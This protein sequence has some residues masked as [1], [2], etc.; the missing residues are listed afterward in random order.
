MFRTSDSTKDRLVASWIDLGAKWVL[1]FLVATSGFLVSGV[2]RKVSP[3]D[4]LIEPTVVRPAVILA[5]CISILAMVLGAK[6]KVRMPLWV[7]ILAFLTIAAS[8][9]VKLTGVRGIADLLANLLSACAAVA[10]AVA[11]A[12]VERIGGSL[13]K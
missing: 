13:G 6:W 11:I 8:I 10:L 5:L 9:A 4:H 3:S 12:Q 1:V 2:H 7:S